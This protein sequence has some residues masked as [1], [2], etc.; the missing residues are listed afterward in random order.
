[1]ELILGGAGQLGNLGASPD[2]F[3]MDP[4]VSG[5][6]NNLKLQYFGVILGPF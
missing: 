3:S 5:F 6:E 1:M 4:E 2:I